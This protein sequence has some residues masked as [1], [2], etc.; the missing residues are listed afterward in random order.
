M[1]TYEWGIPVLTPNAP[2]LEETGARGVVPQN[3]MARYM[4]RAEEL[5]HGP[6]VIEFR[7]GYE[8]TPVVLE[9]GVRLVPDDTYVVRTYQK[10]GDG[11]MHEFVLKNNGTVIGGDIYLEEYAEYN[12]LQNYGRTWRAWY[13]QPTQE[14]MAIEPWAEVSA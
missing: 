5:P 1:I 10:G 4:N 9:D 14:Q 3:K 12:E 13:G 11:Q 2:T 6:I 7:A 8:P